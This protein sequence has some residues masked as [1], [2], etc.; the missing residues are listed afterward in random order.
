MPWRCA[1]VDPKNLRALCQRCHNAYDAPHRQRTREARKRRQMEHE[2]GQLFEAGPDGGDTVS[3]RYVLSPD[4]EIHVIS[5]AGDGEFTFCDRDYV[6]ADSGGFQGIYIL[7][8][9]TCQQCKEAV[10][11]LRLSLAGVRWRLPLQ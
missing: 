6:Q 4:G 3:A 1:G 5:N 8:P 10:D 2:Q 9:A 11:E 7:G